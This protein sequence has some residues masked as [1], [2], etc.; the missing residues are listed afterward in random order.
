MTAGTLIKVFDLVRQKECTRYLIKLVVQTAAKPGNNVAQVLSATSR[1]RVKKKFNS[2]A[3]E[4]RRTSTQM[5]W[6]EYVP[7]R[8][9]TDDLVL[10]GESRIV[11]LLSV[12]KFGSALGTMAG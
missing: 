6:G 5:A 7:R 8:G 12:H 9:G 11:L 1:S 2:T 4:K 10:P 3:P